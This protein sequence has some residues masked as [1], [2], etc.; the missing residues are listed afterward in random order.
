MNELKKAYEALK[1]AKL[2][3]ATVRRHT[4]NGFGQG[5]VDGRNGADCG[6]G[7]SRWLNSSQAWKEGY[8]AGWT[9]VSHRE[10]DVVEVKALW[11]K[12]MQGGR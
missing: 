2:N 9:M 11:T 7:S 1:A 4:R 6:R 3:V 8:E 10:D 12:Y 5:V